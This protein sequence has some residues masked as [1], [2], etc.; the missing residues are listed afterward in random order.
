[1]HKVAIFIKADLFKIGDPSS[2]EM[3]GP[4]RNLPWAVSIISPKYCRPKCILHKPRSTPYIAG[5]LQGP[6]IIIYFHC[7]VSASV[8]HAL[9]GSYI[10]C[11]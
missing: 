10:T 11:H 1:M 5:R 8:C 9:R 6:N 3:A 7:A 2:E 4:Y